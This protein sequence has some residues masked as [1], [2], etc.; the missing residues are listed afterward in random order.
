MGTIISMPEGFLGKIKSK[1]VSTHSVYWLGYC[2]LSVNGCSCWL[3]NHSGRQAVDLSHLWGTLGA[4]SSPPSLSSPGHS[5]VSSFP[6]FFL[7]PFSIPPTTL[8][9][10]KRIELFILKLNSTLTLRKNN[11]CNILYY[12]ISATF[13]Q[14]L[15]AW[16]EN[17]RPTGRHKLEG[18]PV[19]TRDAQQPA[20]PCLWEEA[21]FLAYALVLLGN[22]CST[23]PSTDGEDNSNLLKCWRTGKQQLID[24]NP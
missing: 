9:G 22:L 6:S 24:W 15:S 11:P 14:S 18:L 16:T 10:W 3:R 20:G 21:W 5:P 2:R 7:S 1:R 17:Y 13:K 4:Y 12:H 23:F 8:R 19:W